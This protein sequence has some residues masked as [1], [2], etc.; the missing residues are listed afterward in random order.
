MSVVRRPSSSAGEHRSVGFGAPL[1]SL[2]EN[3]PARPHTSEVRRIPRDVRERSRPA[4]LVSSPP[5]MS[6]TAPDTPPS[7]ATRNSR[8]CRARPFPSQESRKPIGTLSHVSRLKESRAAARERRVADYLTPPEA[9]PPGMTT[10]TVFRPP[11]PRVGPGPGFARARGSAPGPEIFDARE[12]FER[13]R[14]DA[15]GDARVEGY[16]S[17]PNPLPEGY[18]LEPNPSPRLRRR[19]PQPRP[20]PGPVVG[21]TRPTPRREAAL[22]VW[23]IPRRATPQSHRRDGRSTRRRGDGERR[24]RLDERRERLDKRLDERVFFASD[25]RASSFA[26]DPLHAP[27]RPSPPAH[28]VPVSEVAALVAAAIAGEPPRLLGTAKGAAAAALASVSET[29]RRAVTDARREGAGMGASEA[30]LALQRSS[31]KAE[32]AARAAVEAAEETARAAEEKRR[33]AEERRRAAEEALAAKSRGFGK[34]MDETKEALSER[35]RAL[36]A[37]ADAAVNETAATRAELKRERERAEAAAKAAAEA[38]YK[39]NLAK[40]RA[41]ANRLRE[42]ANRLREDARRDASN[43]ASE[44]RRAD[45]E[46]ANVVDAFEESRRHAAESFACLREE[47]TR[48][49]ADA[50]SDA[51]EMRREFDETRKMLSEASSAVA[52]RHRAQLRAGLRREAALRE[53]LANVEKEFREKEREEEREKEREKEQEKEREEVE[54]ALEEELARRTAAEAKFAKYDD[55]LVVARRE[56]DDARRERDAASEVTSTLRMELACASS[57]TKAAEAEAAAAWR[58]A[59]EAEADVEAAAERRARALAET[60]RSTR[61]RYFADGRGA[62][63]DWTSKVWWRR[64]STS[65]EETPTPSPRRREKGARTT[66]RDGNFARWKSASS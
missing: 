57:A 26:S 38:T 29:V 46:R 36:K 44:R 40:A 21:A 62:P 19:T 53:R 2:S 31:A 41:E 13:E 33:T 60:I 56:R 4:R 39:E 15:R 8:A 27:S 64:C 18:G 66:T 3:V 9:A 7:L 63:R 37:R 16:G 58:A 55:S 42:E 34:R 14:A 1:A 59:A 28:L 52:A 20:R 35:C 43:A 10:G 30:R 65:N 12:T 24:E 6:A 49:A 50:A 17:G 54:K 5:L 51:A 22:R 11:P 61:R 48:A 25:H 32:R 23:E 45:V 47:A